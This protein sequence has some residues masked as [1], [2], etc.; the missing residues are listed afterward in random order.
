MIPNY[1]GAELNSRS[2]RPILLLVNFCFA[3]QVMPIKPYGLL[4]EAEFLSAESFQQLAIKI[5]SKTLGF[6]S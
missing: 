4:T 3:F 5:F 1:Y 6:P 2:G